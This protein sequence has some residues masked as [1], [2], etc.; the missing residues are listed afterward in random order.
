MSEELKNMLDS[1]VKYVIGIVDLKE[2]KEEIA[3]KYNELIDFY[4]KLYILTSEDLES[5]QKDLSETESLRE[6][7]KAYKA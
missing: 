4:G 3:N 1:F 7:I 2:Y 5:F 6:Q